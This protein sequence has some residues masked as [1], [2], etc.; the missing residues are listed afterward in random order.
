MHWL[1]SRKKITEATSKNR[2]RMVTGPITATMATLCQIGW[3]PIGAAK[4]V[5]PRQV[6]WSMLHLTPGHMSV[7]NAELTQTIVTMPSTPY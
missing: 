6:E 4:W 7:K 3:T 5:D 1:K 2:W